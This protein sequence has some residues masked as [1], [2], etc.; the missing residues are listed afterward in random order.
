MALTQHELTLEEFLKLP[1]EAPALEYFD[2]VVTQ[3]MTPLGHHS[4]LQLKL[5]AWIDDFAVPRRLAMAFMEQRIVAGTASP[6]PDIAVYRGERIP[7]DATGVIRNEVFPP[8]DLAIEI[9]SPGQR[10]AQLT[11]KC[12]WY[13]TQGASLVLLIDPHTRT[14]RVFAP[15]QPTRTLRGADVIDLAPV[16]PGLQLPVQTLFDWLVVR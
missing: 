15:G 3:K 1:D 16:V 14:V 4:R 7:R 2:G 10:M 6:V 11:R 13:I 5:G 12:A 8:A 9:L